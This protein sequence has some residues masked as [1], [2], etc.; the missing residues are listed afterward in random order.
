M[1]SGE[2]KGLRCNEFTNRNRKMRPHQ[3]IPH[4]HVLAAFSTSHASILADS[5]T[6]F[7]SMPCFHSFIVHK[8]PLFF[9]LWLEFFTVFPV[10]RQTVKATPLSLSFSF[11]RG[12]KDPR[13]GHVN[14]T[15]AL[16]W[17]ETV[18]MY[19]IMTTAPRQTVACCLVRTNNTTVKKKKDLDNIEGRHKKDG[20]A[21]QTE[22]QLTQNSVHDKDEKNCKS[23]HCLE[24]K[25][26]CNCA[27]LPHHWGHRGTSTSAP[28]VTIRRHSP[29]EDF[30]VGA[31]SKPSKP[32]KPPK[33]TSL[34][35][36]AILQDV[37]HHF[38]PPV[39]NFWIFQSRN[40]LSGQKSSRGT[41]IFPG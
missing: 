16:L 24:D 20:S 31:P 35:H 38:C 28:L 34:R 29:R 1:L 39:S 8:G 21:K 25:S 27:C 33:P 11:G 15:T 2:R 22:Q 41:A 23:A 7:R 37:R 13:R 36:T 26:N 12:M 10:L 30:H 32:S 3:A 40:S 4:L 17:E 6:R 9:R 5:S 18:I 19:T 14:D